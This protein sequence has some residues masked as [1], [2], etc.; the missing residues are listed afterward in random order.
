MSDEP[1][2]VAGRTDVYAIPLV[3][4]IYAASA[5][6][7][8]DQFK[9]ALTAGAKHILL[10]CSRLEQV[11]STILSTF[12]AGLK[13]VKSQRGGKIVF[14]AVGEHIKRILSLTKMDQYFPIA[15]DEKAAIALLD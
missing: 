4:K 11:D 8:Q 3:G 1:R 7:V 10:D 15:A 6:S 9:K 2:P 5:S 13:L 12:I 14:C